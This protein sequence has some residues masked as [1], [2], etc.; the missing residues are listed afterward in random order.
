MPFPR[1]PQGDIIRVMFHRLG[2]LND[3]SMICYG[4][5]FQPWGLQMSNCDFVAFGSSIDLV[6]SRLSH[7]AL[8]LCVV[9]ALT[10]PN[11]SVQR[12]IVVALW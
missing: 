2:V 4:A 11:Q 9:S 7:R 10:R 1:I 6:A 3:R 12:A 8:A 5:N